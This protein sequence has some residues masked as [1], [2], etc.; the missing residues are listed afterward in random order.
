MEQVDRKEQQKHRHAVNLAARTKEGRRDLCKTAIVA[1]TFQNPD[2]TP[3]A[4]RAVTNLF[5]RHYGLRNRYL[6]PDFDVEKAPEVKD[7]PN[8]D[9]LGRIE[10]ST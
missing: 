4:L 6:P 10:A 5:I 1:W 8:G 9:D 7:A 3:E 2:W